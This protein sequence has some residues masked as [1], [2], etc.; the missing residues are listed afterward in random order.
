[1]KGRPVPPRQ[2]PAD[3]DERRVAACVKA[4]EHIS[5]AA[6]ESGL[7]HD[8]LNELGLLQFAMALA[9]R[10]VAQGKNPADYFDFARSVK[11][12][13]AISA[14]MEASGFNEAANRAWEARTGQKLGEDP[15]DIVL[16]PLGTRK[17]RTPAA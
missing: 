9:A 16:A 1:M 4:C 14:R 7:V 10:M 17:K 5:A 8:A 13:A 6:L 3:A 11:Q 15:S 2:L 12:T